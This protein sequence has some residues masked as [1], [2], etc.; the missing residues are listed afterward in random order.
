MD[1]CLTE[2]IFVQKAW[3]C[4]CCRLLVEIFHL[5]QCISGSCLFSVLALGH[6]EGEKC[7]YWVVLNHVASWLEKEM[8]VI[9][10]K[11]NIVN[12]EMNDSR[13]FVGHCQ[14]QGSQAFKWH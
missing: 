14:N 4:K 12:K 7:E 1:I 2:L 3:L 13:G 11:S 6:A 8:N 5:G 9:W 10:R